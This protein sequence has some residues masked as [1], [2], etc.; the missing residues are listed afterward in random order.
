MPFDQIGPSAPTQEETS[1]N[2]YIAKLIS[3]G[4]QKPA[5]YEFGGSIGRGII[6]GLF[7]AVGGIFGNSDLG[8]QLFG[9][10]LSDKTDTIVE[11]LVKAAGLKEEAEARKETMAF[12][13]H[14][15][16]TQMEYETQRAKDEHQHQQ[17]Q[18][19]IQVNANADI[20]QKQF[21]Q[22]DKM[23]GLSQDQRMELAKFTSKL[24]LDAQNTI[25]E[26][27]FKRM[28]QMARTQQGWKV[29]D[30]MRDHSQKL[31]ELAKSFG[32][33]KD[34]E[35]I[36]QNA[37]TERDKIKTQAATTMAEKDNQTKENIADKEAQSRRE[38]A[39]IGAAAE[40]KS[41][42]VRA[43]GDVQATGIQAEAKKTADAAKAEADATEAAQK[44][45]EKTLDIMGQLKATVD[46]MTGQ[47]DKADIYGSAFLNDRAIG[48]RNLIT[49]QTRASISSDA[50]SFTPETIK[51][52]KKYIAS[53]MGAS[54]DNG[55]PVEMAVDKMLKEINNG[56]EAVKTALSKSR[57]SDIPGGKPE[58]ANN[59]Y[60]M[61]DGAVSKQRDVMESLLPEITPDLALKRDLKE[62]IN[63]ANTAISGASRIFGESD[64]KGKTIDLSYSDDINMWSKKYQEAMENV[65]NLLF[66]VS[67]RG[68]RMSGDIKLYNE[69]ILE[70]LQQAQAVL[71]GTNNATSGFYR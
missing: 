34:L 56:A 22:D 66:N 54:L 70:N 3:A 23:A 29:L 45:T 39:G 19:M 31:D 7:N 60:G 62:K 32:F 25:K 42:E 18:L 41:A 61:I 68:G 43:A 27:E 20:L 44:Q 21:A 59:I 55:E 13:E 38:V 12:Q 10:K 67:S 9:H 40:V 16:K 46:D 47:M 30:A 33:S 15:M 69:S 37:E 71:E 28:M 65:R 48:I 5:E 52:F 6:G 58:V 17:N 53:R 57:Q 51:D 14:L 11:A 2:A 35:L 64:M 1:L 49:N 36:K 50:V 24:E 8:G 26:S 63:R 4:Q